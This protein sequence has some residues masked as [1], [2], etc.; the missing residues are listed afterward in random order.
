VDVVRLRLEV[1]VN[2]RPLPDSNIGESRGRVQARDRTTGSITVFDLGKSGPA[3][4]AGPIFAGR[5][6]LT[7]SLEEE[8]VIAGIEPPASTRL[9]TD[10]ELSADRSLAFDVET[11][12]VS[13]A[14][15]L[16]G[17]VMPDSDESRGTLEFRTADGSDYYY[18]EVGATG[19]ASFET[20]V[21]AGSYDVFFQSPTTAV[22]AL[23]SAAKALVADEL[24]LD[25]NH[26]VVFDL[27]T[28]D[29]NVELTSDGAPL[30]PSDDAFRG[31]VSFRD[32]LTNTVYNFDIGAE[33]ATSF[34]ARLFRSDYYVAFTTGGE[35]A[36]PFPAF[37]A[38]RLDRSLALSGGEEL[39][40]DVRPVSVSGAVTLNG[41][42]L[43]EDPNG[44]ARGSVSFRDTSS[45]KV[46][47]FDVGASG[48]AL[49]AGT[50]F[51]GV[52]DVSFKSSY[53]PPDGLPPAGV[54]RLENDVAI[55]EDR[56]GDYA[57]EVVT[58]SG[59]VTSNGETLPTLPEPSETMVAFRDTL[60][61]NVQKLTVG[62]SGPGAFSGPL[63]TG[64]YDA[65]FENGERGYGELPVASTAVARRLAIDSDEAYTFDVR[66]LEIGGQVRVNGGAM[67]DSPG[68][69]TRGAVVLRDKFTNASRVFDIGNSGT[70]SFEAL[71]F[72]GNYDAALETAQET[73]D[74]LPTS[75]TTL[76]AR[77]CIDLGEC[78]AG[79]DDL[80]GAWPFVFEIA[81]WGPLALELSDDGGALSGPFSTPAATGDFVGTRDEKSFTLTAELG[82]TG[83]VPLTLHATLF[84]ACGVSGYATCGGISSYN[85]R[86][87]GFR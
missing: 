42:G 7:L 52:Y 8:G 1:S 22:G 77:G 81:G 24:A 29:V 6:D 55:R 23:P 3:N 51:A 70:A 5:Y 35:I 48:D 76:L 78:N 86:F 2:G 66:P 16:N 69:T 37:G 21:F 45:G 73:L 44:Q 27:R 4:M 87:T 13:G 71:V 53:V 15:T 14:V 84:D 20:V 54:V 26:D 11:V 28:A 36:A 19:E 72:A 9:A 75:T 57:L 39:R 60:S 59:D 82:T 50:L 61:G 67:P 80:G 46:Y 47:D 79:T 65:T 32:L 30:P 40:Y 33:G 10:V 83:C 43:G 56:V 68:A 49:Y 62:A 58:V 64:E 85:P 12:R 34:S 63:F 18:V 74:G 38:T 25:A 41:G 31:Q 17:A